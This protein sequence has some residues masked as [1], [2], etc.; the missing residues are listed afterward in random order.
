MQ[1]LMLTFRSYVYQLAMAAS[2]KVSSFALLLA[3]HLNNE[4]VG[5]AR[6]Q[7]E[8]SDMEIAV[9][10]FVSALPEAIRERAVTSTELKRHIGFIHYW[11]EKGKPSACVGDPVALVQAD[12]PGV[13]RVFDDSQQQVAVEAVGFT[14]SIEPF[15]K[16]GHYDAALREAWVVFKSRMVAIFGLS[17][18]LDGHRL[19]E[20]L[21]GPEGAMAGTLNERERQGY[22]NLLKGLYTLYRNPVF[23]N[24][25]QPDPVET[26]S[27]LAML[28]AAVVRIGSAT[29]G[30]PA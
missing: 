19:V 26:D 11:L 10:A 27:V 20:A 3:Q 30:A 17:E 22:C 9:N 29:S 1:E 21:F 13:L 8:A 18:E 2:A 24:H 12:L 16:T 14:D 7:R 15:I 4:S 6:L 23:H 5:L 25:I 28:D